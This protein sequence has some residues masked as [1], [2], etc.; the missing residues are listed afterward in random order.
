MNSEERTVRAARDSRRRRRREAVI[1]PLRVG[2]RGEPIVLVGVLSMI[3][4]SAGRPNS[5]EPEIESQ[6]T[7]ATLVV[8]K[9]KP[10]EMTVR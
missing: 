10:I 9:L 6:H 7:F 4:S 1:V 3:E 2:R 5:R 8:A